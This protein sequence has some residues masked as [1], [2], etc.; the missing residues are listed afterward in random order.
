MNPIRE[1]RKK[2][3]NLS[4]IFLNSVIQALLNDT[5]LDRRI[6][7]QCLINWAWKVVL[8]ITPWGYLQGFTVF[9]FYS[10]LILNFWVR[11]F[12]NIKI[13]IT[14]ITYINIIL[15]NENMNIDMVNYVVF[16]YQ[17]YSEVEIHMQSSLFFKLLRIS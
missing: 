11:N 9:V 10:V 4:H 14:G 12:L 13:Y 6:T 17:L 8:F 1:R 2:L 5:K 16:L 15:R 3:V 7:Y